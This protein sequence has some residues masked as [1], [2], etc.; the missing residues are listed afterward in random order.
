MR[1]DPTAKRVLR[2]IRESGI[3]SG[4]DIHTRTSIPYAELVIA[5]GKLLEEGLIDAKGNT[6]DERKIARAHFRFRPSD[7]AAISKALGMKK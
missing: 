2:E 6:G 4:R 1:F 5:V 7:E 3:V